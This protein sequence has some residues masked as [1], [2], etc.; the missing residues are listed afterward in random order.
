MEAAG[1]VY[2]YG[3]TELGLT[4]IEARA[5]CDNFASLRII[6]KLGFIW[7]NDYETSVGMFRRHGE[8]D[9]GQQ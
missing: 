8:P 7:L 4:N 5:H 9:L 3:K 6:E 2:D 1:A